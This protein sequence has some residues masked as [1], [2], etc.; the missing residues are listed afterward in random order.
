MVT[1]RYTQLVSVPSTAGSMGAHSFRANS[2]ND[3][4]YTGTGHQPRGYDE[5]S[6]I[7]KRYTVLGA[8]CTAQYMP[9]GNVIG[10]TQCFAILLNH[11]ATLTATK[12]ANLIERK[13]ARW[14]LRNTYAGQSA[15]VSVRGKRYNAKRF[16]GLADVND[17]DDVSALV[18]ADPI[19]AA[20]FH[21][22]AGSADEITTPPTPEVLVTITYKV[23]FTDRKDL[24]PSM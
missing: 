16:W 13:Q 23:L 4:D 17:N 6:L 24:L 11:D 2:I 12:A 5:M 1:M 19:K 9:E 21:V 14:K 20:Y 3:P 18:T 8:T 15:P 22:M 7:F 10:A